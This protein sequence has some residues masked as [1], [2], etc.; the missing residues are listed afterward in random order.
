MYT[1]E[2]VRR[3]RIVGKSEDEIRE[4]ILEDQALD[5]Q[6]YKEAYAE[7]MGVLVKMW[8]AVDKDVDE[9]RLAVYA[10]EFQSIPLGLLEKAVSRAIRNNGVYLSVPS[11]GAL[12]IAIQKEIGDL[13]NMDV[14]E[15]VNLWKERQAEQFDALL[16]RFDVPIAVETTSKE[17]VHAE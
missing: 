7:W 15:V 1:D 2:M 6:I 13:P 16:Y 9:K 3:L 17:P 11:V 12:W 5:E 14:M 8:D 4:I 10:E